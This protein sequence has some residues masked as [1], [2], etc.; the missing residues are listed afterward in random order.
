MDILQNHPSGPAD[1]I[2]SRGIIILR[3]VEI[4]VIQVGVDI[5]RRVI[6]AD[7]YE[8]PGYTE[9]VIDIYIERR[10]EDDYNVN[11]EFVI[12][13]ASNFEE[14]YSLQMAATLVDIK[15]IVTNQIRVMN[16]YPTSAS[17]NQDAILAYAERQEGETRFFCN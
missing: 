10:E 2:L 9:A 12:E 15:D 5:A 4:P 17:I 3:G 8:I 11:T 14:R 16:P 6:S 13:P 1:V 7:H